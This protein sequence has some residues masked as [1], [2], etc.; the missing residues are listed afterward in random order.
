MGGWGRRT[1]DTNR[2]EHFDLEPSNLKSG[3]G[4]GIRVGSQWGEA[5]RSQSSEAAERERGSE[6]AEGRERRGGSTG[7][8]GQRALAEPQRKGGKGGSRWPPN[9]A[10]VHVG[11]GGKGGNGRR[12]QQ[13]S[14]VTVDVLVRTTTSGALLLPVRSWQGMQYFI[15]HQ[16]P[17]AD[18]AIGIVTAG[19]LAPLRRNQEREAAF[20]VQTDRIAL[21]TI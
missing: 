13:Q 10:S 8:R 12:L 16:I 14:S 19:G 17:E 1:W 21:Q 20:L 9:Q 11:G 3:P 15:C 6:G 5:P 2:P 18:T 7:L 4:T